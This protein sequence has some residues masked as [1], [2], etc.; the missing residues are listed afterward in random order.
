MLKYY[1]GERSTHILLTN[2]G[3][4]ISSFIASKKMRI[5]WN[6]SVYLPA[7]YDTSDARYSVLFMFHGAGGHQLNFLERMD[8]KGQLDA[9]HYEGIVVFVDGFNSFYLDGPGYPMESMIMEEL[10]PHY[11]E[12]Y[13]TN[14]DIL[15]GGVS[16]GGYGA[17]RLSMK[18]PNTFKKVFAIA[19]AVWKE[20]TPET[21]TYAWSI[22]RD[23]DGTYDFEKYYTNH[24][25]SFAQANTT[26][27]Y[28]ETGMLDTIVPFADVDATV[29]VF[30]KHAQVRYTQIADGDH[31]WPYFAAAV[32]R[33]LNA[34]TE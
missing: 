20:M 5:D 3:T 4:I 2:S 10:I 27:Y 21:E 28:I 32:Q 6:S 29:A 25:V 23:E 33:G 12:K 15:L 9:M 24:P 30:E 7:S 16:M 14:G 11:L 1:N 31:G 22:F 34:I 19:P 17:L 26:Q 13:R 18:H 8:M